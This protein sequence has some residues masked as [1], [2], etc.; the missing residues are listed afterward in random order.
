MV[1][2]WMEMAETKPGRCDRCGIYALLGQG[3]PY[4]ATCLAILA[5]GKHYLYTVGGI[6]AGPLIRRVR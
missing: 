3:H 5:E 4:C 2:E 1:K 6:A